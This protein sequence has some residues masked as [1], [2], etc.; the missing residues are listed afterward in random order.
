MKK[1]KA[2]YAEANRLYKQARDILDG[3]GE[4]G[5]SAEKQQQVDQLLDQVEAKTAE[6]KRLERVAE[7][8]ANFDAPADDAPLGAGKAVANGGAALSPAVKGLGQILG[9]PETRL[10]PSPLTP[11]KS[12]DAD[13]EV[14]HAIATALFWQHGVKGMDAA[15]AQLPKEMRALA[16]ELKDL[17]TSPGGGGGYLVADT[18]RRQLIEDLED[19]VAMRRIANVLPPI[20]GGSSITPSEDSELDDAEWTTEVKT[21]SDDTVKPF[22]NRTLTPHPLAKRIKI[23]RTL[24]RAA[25]LINVE[26]FVLNRMAR[27]F[28]YAE[29]NAFIQGTGVRQPLGLLNATGIA[30]TETASSGTLVADDIINWAYQLDAKYQRRARIICNQ[31]FLRKVRLMRSDSGAGAG[32]GDY[33][34]QPGLQ[35]G[36]PGIILD[37]PYEISDYYPTGL[38]SDTYQSGETVATIGDFMYYH[39]VDSLQL[40]IQRLEELYAETNQVG[41]IGRKETDGMVVK[42]EA[43]RHLDIQ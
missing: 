3:A 24:L 21:G 37:F 25:T 15:L 14:K 32:T 23:S 11:G 43:F 10:A 12:Y 34:W 6:A 16:G 19:M 29:E 36:Q 4:D 35:R 20:P 38:S 41:F 33:L 40:E 13:R 22:G 30:A 7:M 2:L 31:S 5:L 26:Q 17:A 8:E 27:K 39:I 9:L 42:T 28:S 18:H 1:I